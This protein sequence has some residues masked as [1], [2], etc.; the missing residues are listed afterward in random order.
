VLAELRVENLGVI[1]ELSLVLGEGM[2][3]LT[4]ET[5]A[6]KT[7]VIEAITLLLGGR[8]DS[9]LVRAGADEARVE[10]RFVTGDGAETVLARVVPRDGRSRAYVDGRMATVQTLAEM[11]SALVD[12]HGQHA[13][14]TLFS[15]A[16]QRRALDTFAA[17]DIDAWRAARTRVA[18]IDQQLAELGGDERSR[19]RE[20]DLIGF[21]ITEIERAAIADAD[22]GVRLRAE[23]DALAD[24]VAHREAADA[25]TAALT[26]EGGAVDL[27]RGA[28][29][30]LGGRAPFIDPERRLRSLVTEFD[31]VAHEIRAAGDAIVDDPER[32]AEIRQRRAMLREL[33]RKYGETLADVLAELDVLRTRHDE[34]SSHAER[35]GA[36]E[37][38]RRAALAEQLAAAKVIA[39]ARVAGAPGLAAAIGGH[40]ASLAL[41]G[42]RIEVAVDGPPP[43][44]EVRFELAANPGEPALPL[45]KVA[46]GGELARVMLALRLVLTEAPDTLVFDEVDAGIGGD[47]A[48]AVGAALGSLGAR[49]QV[50]VVTHLAQ[51][52][53]HAHHQVAVAKQTVD[54]RTVTE[55]RTVSGDDR[56]TELARMLSGTSARRSAEQHARDLLGAAGHAPTS[57]ARKARR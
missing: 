37:R 29:A 4:G 34:L 11:G 13:N 17:I 23:E 47:A 45:T 57:R 41:P 22:E 28:V 43:A 10:G 9:T 44:D 26:D 25:A 49:H 31:D 51:V 8:A 12:L 30:S 40:L 48:H 18:E 20:L 27:I 38:D 39:A 36:L 56:V 50:I 19:A 7:L 35:V 14:Q 21:Q 54:G 1:A 6:G 52:A 15:T 24:A 53:A 42:A 33:R 46:S 5:G 16:T 2:T 32:L 3:A 55:A